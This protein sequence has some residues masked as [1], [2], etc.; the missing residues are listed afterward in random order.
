MIAYYKNDSGEWVTIASAESSDIT[1]NSPRFTKA[2]GESVNVTEALEN[3]DQKITRVTK[4]LAWIYQNGAIGGGGGG[5]SSDQ[6]EFNLIN[7]GIITS[8]GNKYLFVS[9]T[10]AKVSFQVKANRKNVKFTVSVIYNGSQNYMKDQ[11]IDANQIYEIELTNIDKN[12]RNYLQFTG[13]DAEG[14]S[15]EPEILY[16]DAGSLSLTSDKPDASYPIF[17]GEDLSMTFRIKNAI[18]GQK[19]YLS[20]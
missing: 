14:F 11:V 2:G 20:C 8:A 16:V 12:E 15:I 19:S 1:V 7:P 13:F 4:N 9:D 3:I 5:G 10:T 18:I 6:P 17:L